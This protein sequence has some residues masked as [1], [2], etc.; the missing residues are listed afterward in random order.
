MASDREDR[1]AALRER[2]ALFFY[3]FTLETAALHQWGGGCQVSGCFLS[4]LRDKLHDLHAADEAD[5][6]I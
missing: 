5:R 2:V 1:T 3:R 6:L 4:R